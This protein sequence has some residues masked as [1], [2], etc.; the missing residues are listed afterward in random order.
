VLDA[1]QAH[2]RA[3]SGDRYRFAPKPTGLLPLADR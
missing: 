2:E 1:T 3:A